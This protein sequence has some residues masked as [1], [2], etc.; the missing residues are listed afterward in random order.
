[1]NI[2]SR[3]FDPTISPYLEEDNDSVGKIFAY[4]HN[5]NSENESECFQDM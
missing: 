3:G 2:F 4:K 1:M 5:F